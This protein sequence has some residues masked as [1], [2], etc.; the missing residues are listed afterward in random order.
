M[1]VSRMSAR[2]EPRF[3]G[4]HVDE[5][6]DLKPSRWARFGQV[7]SI[8]RRG[9]NLQTT[10]P[11]AAPRYLTIGRF[12][13]MCEMSIV[14]LRHYD[15][16]GILHPARVNAETGYR[17]YKGE[18]LRTA[19]VVRLLRDLDVPL[20]EIRG[21]LCHSEQD[22]L[23]DVLRRHRERIA[24]R[25]DEAVQIL[26]R[27]DRVL[28]GQCGLIPTDVHLVNLKPQWVIS[29]RAQVPLCQDCA[30]VDHL[31]DEL[32]GVARASSALT[33]QREFVIYYNL[34]ARRSANDLEVC[35]PVKAD[36]A[37]QLPGVSRLAGGTAATLTHR[38]P[39]DELHL[40]YAALFG[41]IREHDYDLAGAPRETYLVDE[42]DEDD[43][44]G[45]VTRLD[46]P[47]RLSPQ[48]L[49]RSA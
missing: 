48:Q 1:L 47:V 13:D 20:E 2:D 23:R 7:E 18:Q 44:R 35:V 27:L 21:L 11:A 6:S 36:R 42:R 32:S 17:L 41:W 4:R 15:R 24:A 22:D 43:P 33:S 37:R 28:D 10:V 12:A 46:W 30:S 16:L 34:L 8:A 9:P 49:R 3:A 14:M 19:V 40:I 29:R 39:W 26:S 38:G 45:Y 5:A 25:R 31:I